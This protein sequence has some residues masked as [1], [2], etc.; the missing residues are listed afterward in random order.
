VETVLGK[1][2]KNLQKLVNKFNK[3]VPMVEEHKVLYVLKWCHEWMTEAEL[4]SFLTLLKSTFGMTNKPVLRGPVMRMYGQIIEKMKQGPGQI[5][6]WKESSMKKWKLL[7]EQ[8]R[9]Q[10]MK[11]RAR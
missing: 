10:R 6:E 9:K 4:S 3:N 5:S 11:Q 2:F 7:K 1:A 8:E